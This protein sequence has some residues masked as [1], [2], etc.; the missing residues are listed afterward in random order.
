MNQER[1]MRVIVAPVVS[2]KTNNLAE[3]EEQ[4]VLRVL[5]DASKQEIKAAVELLFQA[6]VRVVNT[7]RQKGKK[8]RFGRHMGKR[9]EIKKAYITLVP[10]QHLDVGAGATT[11]AVLD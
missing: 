7:L 3:K 2:E 4:I 1:L 6:Q 8:K 10:G 5:R 11:K 9:Q